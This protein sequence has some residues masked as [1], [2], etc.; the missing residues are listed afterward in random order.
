MAGTGK[1][2]K[3]QGLEAWNA[4]RETGGAGVVAGVDAGTCHSVGTY[5]GP[6]AMLLPGP[7]VCKGAPPSLKP[8]LC[9]PVWVSGDTVRWHLTPRLGQSGGSRIVVIT[10]V[11]KTNTLKGIGI[12]SLLGVSPAS[13]SSAFPT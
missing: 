6:P 13:P 5:N 7:S 10:T 8:F 9:W 2:L 4:G 12:C 1:Q 3:F 11:K